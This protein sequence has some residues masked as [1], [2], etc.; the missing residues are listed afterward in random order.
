VNNFVDED[1]N[2]YFTVGSRR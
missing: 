1:G 2:F